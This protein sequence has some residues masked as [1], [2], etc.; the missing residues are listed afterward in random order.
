MVNWVKKRGILQNI[1]NK[2]EFEKMVPFYD[3]VPIIYGT[4]HPEKFTLQNVIGKAT[5][6]EEK[7]EKWYGDFW[8]DLDRLDTNFANSLTI[9]AKIP[10]STQLWGHE[11]EGY[12]DAVPVHLLMHPDL[13]PKHPD[14]GTINN[15]GNSFIEIINN[16]GGDASMEVLQ[17][18]FAELKDKHAHAELKKAHKKLGEDH[19]TLTEKHTTL[20]GDIKTQLVKAIITANNTYKEEELKEKSFDDLKTIKNTLDRVPKSQDTPIP[21]NNTAIGKSMFWD[22]KSN[23]RHL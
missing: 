11:K 21:I 18:E 23:G 8:Y 17:K 2:E 6:W 1:I 7:N 22:L 19:K 15:T 4:E 20:E 9:G 10:A 16:Q 5:N 3:S 14:A 13:V 12:K